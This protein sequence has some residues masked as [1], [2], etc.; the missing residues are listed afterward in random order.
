M[1]YWFC[2]GGWDYFAR[3]VPRVNVLT[4]IWNKI[5][6]WYSAFEKE[7]IAQKNGIRTVWDTYSSWTSIS[8]ISASPK[9]EAFTWSYCYSIYRFNCMGIKACSHD[10]GKKLRLYIITIWN[11]SH[12]TV[13]S[14]SY[15][16]WVI[17]INLR[18]HIFLH[19]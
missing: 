7:Q 14:R 18:F 10:A 12:D 3:N 16:N 1:F 11:C 19:S 13:P 6:F 8:G 9:H 2:H 4:L 15:I 17:I 5:S